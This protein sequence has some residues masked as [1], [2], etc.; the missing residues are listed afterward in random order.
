[1]MTIS[2]RPEVFVEGRWSHN[3]LRFATEA[4]ATAN[5]YNLMMRWTPVEDYR[6]AESSDPVNYRWTDSGL[7]A[8]E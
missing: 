8:I 7:E 5:A 4:E 3:G 1:M 2:W 6:A